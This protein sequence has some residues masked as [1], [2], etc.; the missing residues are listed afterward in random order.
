MKKL[1]ALLSVYVAILILW[2]ATA[3]A[4]ITHRDLLGKYL[5]SSSG[6]KLIAQEDFKPFPKTAEEWRKQLPDSI[7]KIIIKN[8]EE[9]L[10]KKFQPV[11][12]TV[13]L[14][15]VRTGNRIH[16]ERLSFVK[17]DMLW[18]LVLAEAAEGK[19]RFIDH[20][21]DGLWS[22]CEE[23]YWG[24]PVHLSLQKAGFGLA[25]V[26]DPTVDLFAAETAS[27]LAWTDYFMGDKLDKISPLLRP[28][29]YYEVNRRIFTPMD[30]AHYE[31]MGNGNPDAKL[32]NWAPWI[33]SNYLAAA[34]LLEKNT[35][36]RVDAVNRCVKITDQYINGLGNDGGCDEGPGY[37]FAAGASVFDVLNLLDDASAGKVN[38]HG[39]PFVKKIG[40]YIYQTHIGGS[41]FINVADAHPKIE[42]DGTMIYRFGK[43]INDDQMTRFGSWA[44]YNLPLHETEVET[45]R[46]ARRLYNLFSAGHIQKFNEPYHDL[47]D[48]WYNDVQLMAS[49]SANGLFV[50]AH[51]GNN[52][53]SH[54]HNDVGDFMVYANNYPVIIDVGTGTY[55]ARTFSKERYNL[56]FNTS[57][58]HNLP[59]INNNQQKDGIAYVASAVKYQSDKNHSSLTMDIKNAY[60][61]NTGITYWQRNVEMIK[62]GKIQ[63]MDNYRSAAPL[64]SLTQTFMTVCPTDITHPGKILFSLPDQTIVALDYDVTYWNIKKEK[65]E[66]NSPEGQGLKTSWD[67]Q[68]IYRVLLINKSPASKATIKYIIYKQNQ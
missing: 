21:V 12:A 46:R 28:R 10:K 34:L 8:G 43:L 49:R 60:P 27:I 24:L 35:G 11:P 23:T 53:E 51:G 4:Q 1:L 20:V 39:D 41:Y 5:F 50:A 55:T 42:I 33:V 38:I 7:L 16:Y 37:W 25:D 17:R 22:T 63:V 19:G 62:T 15:Y 47:P 32:N 65:M 13:M 44:V 14:E 40:S 59:V 3:V 57:A 67:H 9:A 52:G 36:K 31:W 64:K 54:N 30:T 26:Q 2:S 56:W 6:N 58:Y 48:V 68:D 61:A 66:L 18:D 29:I 45:F